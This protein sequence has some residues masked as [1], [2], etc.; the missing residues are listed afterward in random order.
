[1]GAVY[2]AVHEHLDKHVAIKVMH[3]EFA[4]D[5]EALRRFYREAQAA[6]ATGHSGVVP[7]HDI[8]QDTRGFHFMVMDF[9]QGETLDARL[10]SN[11]RLE[12]W[13]ALSIMC[14]VLDTLEVVHSKGIL[15]RDIKPENIFLAKEISGR[16]SAKILDFGVSRHIGKDEHD[17]RLTSTGAILGTP[18]YLSPEQ[19]RGISDVDNRTDIYS[20]GVILYQLLSGELPFQGE[21]LPTLFVKILTSEPPPLGSL[22]LSLPPGLEEIVHKSIAREREERY[23]TAREFREAL[24]PYCTP[25]GYTQPFLRPPGTGLSPDI[26]GALDT[27]PGSTSTAWSKEGTSTR[28]SRL[29]LRTILLLASAGTLAFVLMAAAVSLAVIL[30]MFFEGRGE[31]D[32]TSSNAKEAVEPAVIPEPNV[33]DDVQVTFKDLPR[34]AVVSLDGREI[35]NPASIRRLEQ[36]IQIQIEAPGYQSQT[37][38][39][40]PSHDME[41]SLAMVPTPEEETPGQPEQIPSKT[42]SAAPRTTGKKT[43]GSEKP[44]LDLDYTTSKHKKYGLDLDYGSSK[45]KDD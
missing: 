23:S 29:P 2:E 35:G 1:M 27:S 38:W 41:I 36:A 7:V 17:K 6:S 18:Y 28:R 44:I 20:C 4:K 24:L 11:D 40:H 37:I 25:T 8:G 34:E 12:V 42:S 31:D 13:D 9:M 15:H 19:A 26:G 39:I 22:C 14:E 30:P 16:R 45:K 10:R 43:S 33:S 3:A 21:T 5:A 32:P